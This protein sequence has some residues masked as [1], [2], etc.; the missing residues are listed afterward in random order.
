MFTFISSV[1]FNDIYEIK[2]ILQVGNVIQIL[3]DQ[4]ADFL[5]LSILSRVEITW[6]YFW[7]SER[8]EVLFL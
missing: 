2:L 5:G 6:F 1:C 7:G 3:N 4:H 8:L